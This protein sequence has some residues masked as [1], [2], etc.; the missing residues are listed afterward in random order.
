[1]AAEGGFGVE[2]TLTPAEKQLVQQV[3]GWNID[4]DPM[5]KTAAQAALAFAGRLNLD[6]YTYQTYGAA[7][8]GFTGQVTQAFL[9]N[10]IQ[11]QG[12]GQGTI[13]L[14]TQSA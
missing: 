8:D 14:A 4:A 13:P 10:L 11:E 6:Q 3:T 9:D 7:P 5:G 2:H 12:E 1:L